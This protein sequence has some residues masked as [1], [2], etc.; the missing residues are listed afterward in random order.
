MSEPKCFQK[1]AHVAAVS[2]MSLT[3]PYTVS[4]NFFAQSNFV[5]RFV[6]EEHTNKRV[7]CHVLNNYGHVFF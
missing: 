2:R 3:K 4:L 7:I 6:V 5:G 1:N